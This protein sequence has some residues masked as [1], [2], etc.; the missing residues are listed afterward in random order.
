M[1]SLHKPKWIIKRDKETQLKV[2]RSKSKR[3]AIIFHT[4]ALKSANEECQQWQQRFT[5]TFI[6]AEDSSERIR[7]NSQLSSDVVDVDV[8]FK[9]FCRRSCFN[10]DIVEVTTHLFHYERE[11]KWKIL[12]FE[13]ELRFSLSSVKQWKL[14]VMLS[15]NGKRLRE[16]D[17]EKSLMKQRWWMK[18]TKG[19]R[20]ILH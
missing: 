16:R 18:R 7:A 15:D 1:P 10:I 8:F 4:F 14:S 17:G 6:R 2:W 3:I 13:L 19:G 12:R 11:M 20:R 5:V 9:V